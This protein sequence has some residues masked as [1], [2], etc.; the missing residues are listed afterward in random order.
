M[1]EE[2]PPP[3]SL[4]LL[5]TWYA[6]LIQGGAHKIKPALAL[7]N[8][9]RHLWNTWLSDLAVNLFRYLHIPHTLTIT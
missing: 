9:D 6:E 5:L 8:G 3:R 4:S 2:A 1:M 7:A